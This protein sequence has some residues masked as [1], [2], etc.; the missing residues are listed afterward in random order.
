L[1]NFL[2]KHTFGL[3]T[4][5]TSAFLVP[6]TTPKVIDGPAIIKVQAT[7]GANDLV[8]RD[9][10][11]TNTYTPQN[12]M[13]QGKYYVFV[14]ATD[15]I[16]NTSEASGIGSVTIAGPEILNSPQ[17][18][19]VLAEDYPSTDI[20][21]IWSIPIG[22]IDHYNV[23]RFDRRITDDNLYLASLISSTTDTTYKDTNT[24]S[25]TTYFYQVTAVDTNLIESLASTTVI[26][27]S[28]MASKDINDLP[29]PNMAD[30][31]DGSDGNYVLLGTKTI[32]EIYELDLGLSQVMQT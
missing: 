13:A 24:V 21:L 22:L 23:Y 8:N 1:I 26:N 19:S 9:F 11:R 15:K 14:E 3:Q 17:N 28:A 25:G 4:A 10:V 27:D 29:D 18:L 7:S 6:F 5:G 16:S 2:V 12:A 20:N 30:M 31:G 32:K